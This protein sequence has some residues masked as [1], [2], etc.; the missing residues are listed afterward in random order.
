MR[1]GADDVSVE[2]AV[3]LRL[4]CEAHDVSIGPHLDR[5]TGY[6]CEIARRM[7]LPAA[8]VHELTHAVPLHDIGKIGLPV[9]LLNKPGALEAAEREV[10]KTH[11]LIGHRILEGS[12]WPVIQCAAR[13]ALS[14]HEAWDGTGYPHRWTAERIPLEARISCVA[15]VFDALCSSRAYK[16]AWDLGQVVDEMRR[17]RGTKFDPGIV[18]L[19]LAEIPAPVC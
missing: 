4:A 11:T 9:S 19:F 6:A 12:P 14:H 8:R 18:D 1:D 3:R 16:P 2:I 15:D 13:I 5:V 7:G 17:L 10:I